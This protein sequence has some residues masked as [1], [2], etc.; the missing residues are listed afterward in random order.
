MPN[1]KEVTAVYLDLMTE[2][3][4]GLAEITD[5]VKKKHVTR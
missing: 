2:V 5:L 3:K 4:N 1:V